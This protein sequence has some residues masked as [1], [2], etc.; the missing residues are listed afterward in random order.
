MAKKEKK[1]DEPTLYLG[2]KRTYTKE[3]IEKI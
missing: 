1:V 2:P 3:Q